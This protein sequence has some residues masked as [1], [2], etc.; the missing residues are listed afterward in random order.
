MR[1]EACC[2]SHDVGLR[3][4]GSWYLSYTASLSLVRN[5]CGVI[6]C[7]LTLVCDE[8]FNLVKPCVVTSV[9]GQLE[10]SCDELWGPFLH[11]V[12]AL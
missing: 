1:I 8:L 3:H 11:G 4:L 2:R 5:L 12:E 10:H 9:V 6:V 7:L